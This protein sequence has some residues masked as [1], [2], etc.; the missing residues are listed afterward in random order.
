M[1]EHEG[2]CLCGAVRYRVAA[3]PVRVTFCH[4]RFCQRGS[5]AAYAVEP[6]F[7][8]S[9]FSVVQ[10]TA[11][12]YRHRSEGS[13]KVLTVSFCGTCGTKMFLDFERFPDLCGVYAGTFDDPNWFSRSP[14]VAR[15]IFL[16]S[17]QEG[18]VI[19]AGMPTYRQHAIRNDGTPA[20]P[21]IF[22]TPKVIG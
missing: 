11:A 1:A 16:D 17:A 14:E 6:I 2:G 21:E 7:K 12:T 13:G 19:P 22:D 8:R 20:E 4:C 3:E 9:D 18:T 10:G 15:H 5:G